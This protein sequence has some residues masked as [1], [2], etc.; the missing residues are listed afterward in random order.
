MIMV[1]LYGMMA[2][3]WNIMAGYCGQISLG[4]A[5]F[6]GIGAYSSAFLFVAAH[7]RHQQDDD[8]KGQG[9]DHFGIDDQIRFPD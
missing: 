3:S 2:Q 5:V 8:G 4:H 1:F 7:D 6:F 9:K